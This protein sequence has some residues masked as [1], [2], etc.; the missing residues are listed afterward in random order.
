MANGEKRTAT[1]TV[2]FASARGSGDRGFI[3]GSGAARR[4]GQLLDEVR[5]RG[6]QT[7]LR[8]EIVSLARR[9]GIT[10]AARRT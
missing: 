3:P 2:D 4:V 9:Y 1:A 7:E 5:R 8:D 6:E 10:P